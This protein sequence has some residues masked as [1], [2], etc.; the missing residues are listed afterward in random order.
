MARSPSCSRAASPPRMPGRSGAILSSSLR[1]GWWQSS[2]PPDRG[3]LK[4]S[5]GDRHL[6]LV[7]DNCEHLID[8]VATLVETVMQLCP[9]ASVLAT[10]RE[11]MRIQGEAVYRAPALDVP[12]IR[13]EKPHWSLLPSG[14]AA[15]VRC[16]LSKSQ[17]VAG[18]RCS[19]FGTSLR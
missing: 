11:D 16:D 7:L 6:L 8:A 10:S 15:E 13:A 4:T 5:I 18:V 9:R 1:N 14:H 3:M 12:H 17:V 19:V 2:R